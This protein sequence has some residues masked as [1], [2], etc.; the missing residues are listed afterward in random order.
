MLLPGIAATE[1]GFGVSLERE[2]RSKAGFR[3]LLERAKAP[4]NTLFVS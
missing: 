1:V 4:L 2:K 3:V